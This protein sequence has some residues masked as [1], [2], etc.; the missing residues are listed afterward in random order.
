MKRAFI[1]MG[2]FA[3]LLAQSGSAKAF[4][5]QDYM[6]NQT[7]NRW[8]YESYTAFWSDPSFSVEVVNEYG[9]WRLLESDGDFL[10][11]P[12]PAWWWMSPDSGEV[13]MWIGHYG[14]MFDF[15]TAV[16]DTFQADTIYGAPTWTYPEWEVIS[17]DATITTHAGTFFDCLIIERTNP[18]TADTGVREVVFAPDVGVVRYTSATIV[19]PRTVELYSAIVNRERYP[20][21]RMVRWP[22]YGL[23]P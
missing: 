23:T 4:T 1:L 5:A 20:A 7:G 12:N 16:G 13:Y 19:G 14:V 17:D 15:D 6:P 3:L 9:N 2:L 18:N 22:R 10:E 8:T 11:L 21:R